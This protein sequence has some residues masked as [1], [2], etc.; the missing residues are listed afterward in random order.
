MGLC[1]NRW[2]RWYGDGQ[3]DRKDARERLPD[4]CS[5]KYSGWSCLQKEQRL[6]EVI[7]EAEATKRDATGNFGPCRNWI[8]GV[9]FFFFRCGRRVVGGSC[10]ISAKS[11]VLLSSYTAR[12]SMHVQASGSSGSSSGW[13]NSTCT[14]VTCSAQ[15]NNVVVKVL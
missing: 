1:D 3:G 13:C 14:A 12:P 8:C 15:S 5:G 7:I 11:S 10:S 4:S 9:L 6:G 2:D